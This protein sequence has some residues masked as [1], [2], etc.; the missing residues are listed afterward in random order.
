[1]STTN[2]ATKVTADIIGDDPLADVAAAKL[3]EAGLLAADL[4]EPDL[5]ADNPHH[6]RAYAEEYGT[7]AE[8]PHIWNPGTPP[9]THIQT[10]PNHDNHIHTYDELEPMEPLT[11]N[12]ART[13]AHALLAAA[14]HAEQTKTHRTT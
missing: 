5:H 7:N 6:R 8:A 13:L 12:E 1:M 11:A 2:K 14:N 3:A 10:F 4:P 9:I